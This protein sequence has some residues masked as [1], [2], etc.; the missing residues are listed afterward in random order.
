MHDPKALT[1]H[2]RIFITLDKFI[3]D[4][5]KKYNLRY[6][7][8]VKINDKNLTSLYHQITDKKN[9]IKINFNS[10]DFIFDISFISKDIKYLTGMLYFLR[11]HI[12]VA[13][14][15]DGTY[16]QNTFDKRYLMFASLINQCL[17]N[18]WDRIGDLLYAYF[19]TGIKEDSVYLSKVL[20]NFPKEYKSNK[21]Y[22]LLTEIYKSNVKE[23]LSQRQQVV[24]YKQLETMQFLETLKNR[25]NKEQSELL[26]REKIGYPDYYK[27]QSEIAM[28]GFRVVLD[29]INDL[30]DK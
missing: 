10:V 9:K 27:E 15:E 2:S 19:E 1:Q 29:L 11:P 21:N 26:E 12:N 18:F 5:Y 30:P 24:H 17:Y 28:R 25:D 8:E 4:I 13:S 14:K 22:I 16:F 23:L 20:N 3:F 7:D 6:I